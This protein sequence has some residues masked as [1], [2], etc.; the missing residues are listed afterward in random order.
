MEAV[1]GLVH[2]GPAHSQGQVRVGKG[3]VDHAALEARH[4]AAGALA[5]AAEAGDG[6]EDGRV[7]RVQRVGVDAP[8]P[9]R[10]GPG[11]AALVAQKILVQLHIPAVPREEVGHKVNFRV[12]G[13]VR[14]DQV[15]HARGDGVDVGIL[16]LGEP[17]QT[18]CGTDVLGLFGVGEL[19][20]LL[21]NGRVGAGAIGTGNSAR[22]CGRCEGDDAENGARKHVTEMGGWMGDGWGDL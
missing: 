15:V 4:V 16:G 3:S 7:G 8:V 11:E 6:V 5:V 1:S 18:H 21:A 17:A 12:Q 13:E 22:G 14:V 20:P 10:L 9:V 19:A 2:V